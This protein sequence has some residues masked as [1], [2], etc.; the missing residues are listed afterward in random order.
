MAESGK[1][2]RVLSLGS[3]AGLIAGGA[4]IFGD[5]SGRLLNTNK[6]VAAVT[7]AEA[8][9]S[10]RALLSELTYFE[11]LNSAPEQIAL[12]SRENADAK[13]W[14]DVVNQPS[15]ST[16]AE[17]LARVLGAETPEVVKVAATTIPTSTGSAYA[18][19][20]SSFVEYQDAVDAMKKLTAKGYDARIVQGELSGQ[21][22][23]YRVRLH[24]FN[25][26]AEAETAKDKFEQNEN[27]KALVIA[28]N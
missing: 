25:D 26:L 1:I 10:R 19:Q 7:A 12:E 28:Q 6:P 20:V 13:K 23:V 21:Y 4:V 3:I 9:H 11:V 5:Y 18:V 27:S 2:Y 24:G 8:T 14:S 16:V 15:R 22:T 17:A